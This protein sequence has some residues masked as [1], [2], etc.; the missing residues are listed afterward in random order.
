M[1]EHTFWVASDSTATES[2]IL[3]LEVNE[4]ITQKHYYLWRGG[5]RSLAAQ[6]HNNKNTGTVQNWFPNLS[7]IF[8]PATYFF[9]DG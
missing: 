9:T 4:E 3:E 8:L 1:R 5:R 2:W 7:F 6:G